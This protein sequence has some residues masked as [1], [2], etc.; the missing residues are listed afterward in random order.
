[1]RANFTCKMEGE[2]GGGERKIGKIGKSVTASLVGAKTL[3]SPSPS[4]FHFFFFRLL[5]FFLSFF[6]FFSF[7]LLA[8]SFIFPMLLLRLLPS[9]SLFPAAP[10]FLRSLPISSQHLSRTFSS[11]STTP[12]ATPAVS[13]EYSSFVKDFFL[14]VNGLNHLFVSFF[15]L[16][17]SLSSCFFLLLASSFFSSFYL[18][19]IL[20]SSSTSSSF[21]TL[22]SVAH[23]YKRYL[24]SKKPFRLSSK[25]LSDYKDRKPPFGFNGL[26]EFVYKRTYSRLKDDGLSEEWQVVLLSSFFLLFFFLSFHPHYFVNFFFLFSFFLSL[27]KVCHKWVQVQPTTT[28]KISK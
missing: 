12:Q 5:S 25:F 1:M 26:G 19:S 4:F 7:F 6:F 13:E 10:V 22:C 18:L 24:S 9:P 15:F 3:S 23:A 27:V 2:E 21:V 11:D 17:V 16:L 28:W 14:S 8:R 20:F